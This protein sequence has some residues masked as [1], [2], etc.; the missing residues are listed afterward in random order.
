MTYVTYGYGRDTD[1]IG[2]VTTYGLGIIQIAAIVSGSI[3]FGVNLDF[4]KLKQLDANAQILLSTDLDIN[5]VNYLAAN[6][7]IAF[8]TNLDIDT[9][10]Q[11]AGNPE[12]LFNTELSVDL[13]TQLDANKN[14]LFD[15]DLDVEL[16]SF[17]VKL[18]FERLN[19]Y[20]IPEELRFLKVFMESR[21][22]VVIEDNRVETIKFEDRTFIILPKTGEVD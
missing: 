21:N 13:A 20:I 10:N 9:V 14:I 16:A 4:Q 15:I 19:I 18:V 5:T 17:L 7:D 11:L 2:S 1:V 12:I 8:V 3:V 22:C 6:P